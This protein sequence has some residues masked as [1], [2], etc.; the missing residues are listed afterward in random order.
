[1]YVFG[2]QQADTRL[3]GSEERQ[4][5]ELSAPERPTRVV[6]IDRY[7]KPVI[8][9]ALQPLVEAC[10]AVTGGPQREIQALQGPVQSRR[11]G[12][13]REQYRRER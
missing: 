7:R 4:R 6:L 2:Y 1:M 12:T 10:A 5:A 13:H 11:D 9:Q 3:N 8:V